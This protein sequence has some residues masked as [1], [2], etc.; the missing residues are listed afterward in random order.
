MRFCRACCRAADLYIWK[1]T[2]RRFSQAATCVLVTAKTGDNAAE[3]SQGEE[4]RFH[5][6]S[7][8][9]RKVSSAPTFFLAT[10]IT[11]LPIR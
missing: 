7:S 5:G 11:F 8:S 6:G 3:H 10:T 1:I 9:W 4:E 2:D